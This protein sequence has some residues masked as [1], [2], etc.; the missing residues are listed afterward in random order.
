MKRIA[1]ICTYQEPL[2]NLIRN[3]N[4]KFNKI[5]DL[6]NP[7]KE[8]IMGGFIEEADICELIKFHLSEKNINIQTINSQLIKVL[9]QKSFKG[10]PIFMIDLVDSLL[11]QKFIQFPA[12]QL[13]LTPELEEMDNTCDWT[14][15]VLPI[16]FE[17]VIGN[18]I[19]TLTVKEIVILKYASIIGNMF[20]L[21]TLHSLIT[22]NN[23]SL[24]D[25][26][27]ILLKFEVSYILV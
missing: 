7:E 17:K 16:R 25:T 24:M 13:M 21:S 19:D 1:I 22:F 27:N 8:Y 10:I 15:F 11:A 18:I 9:L 14:L 20:D 26:Y 5:L 12:Q 6:I 3:P 23:L 2:I 4:D